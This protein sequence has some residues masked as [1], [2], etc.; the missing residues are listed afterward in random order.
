MASQHCRLSQPSEPTEEDEV[1]EL[2]LKVYRCAMA[3]L[4]FGDTS[5]WDQGWWSLAEAAPSKDVGPLFGQFYCF[6]RS[7]LAAANGTLLCR[8][9]SCCVTCTQEALVLRIVETA[10]RSAYGET[11]CAASQ[12][13]GVDDDLGGVLQA[14]QSLASALARQGLFIRGP[15]RGVAGQTELRRRPSTPAVW[16]P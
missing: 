3:G 5:T 14:A 6:G 15:Q 7:L 1:A 9:E 2:V 8:P 13:L 11:L 16:P 12:L 10:Q 4:C